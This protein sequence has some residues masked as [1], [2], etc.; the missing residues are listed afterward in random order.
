MLCHPVEFDRQATNLI[1]RQHFCLSI[2]IATSN[3]SGGSRQLMYRAHDVSGR[4]TAS[5]R[6]TST[7]DPA[8]ASVIRN[9]RRATP[10]AASDLAH[11]AS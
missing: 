7:S 6:T 4:G 1:V 2:E 9:Q 8:M 10:A 5:G 3:F 11:T